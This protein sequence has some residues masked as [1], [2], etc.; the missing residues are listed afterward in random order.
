MRDEEDPYHKRRSGGEGALGLPS[1][2]I[3]ENSVRG[4]A[5]VQPE[6]LQG[7]GKAADLEMNAS[8][9]N[10]MTHAFEGAE[11]KGR[12]VYSVGSLHISYPYYKDVFPF[13]GESTTLI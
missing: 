9:G 5:G 2:L 8:P 1:H 7:H 11:K 10:L 3:I 12:E 4:M 6:A 13:L